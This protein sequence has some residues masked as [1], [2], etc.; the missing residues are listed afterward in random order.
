MRPSSHPV[1]LASEC[2]IFSQ[3]KPRNCCP[4]CGRNV[5]VFSPQCLFLGD[6][7]DDVVLSIASYLSARDL[8]RLAM[9]CRRFG[10]PSNQLTQ[11]N[12]SNVGWLPIDRTGKMVWVRVSQ[13]DLE[14][15]VGRRGNVIFSNAGEVAK[16]LGVDV[17][18]M[19]KSLQHLIERGSRSLMEEVAYQEAMHVLENEYDGCFQWK[20]GCIH[21]GVSWMHTRDACER[22][23]QMLR[24]KTAMMNEL[25]S[26][27]CLHMHSLSTLLT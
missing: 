6:F 20:P 4:T 24:D 14:C 21:M 13:I 19:K 23:L 27:V 22:E 5:S 10:L 8:G 15:L 17:A 25:V 7:N 12:P 2:C 11:A 18:L 1:T 26:L 16:S 3:R 9:T